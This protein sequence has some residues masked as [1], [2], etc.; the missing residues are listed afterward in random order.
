MRRPSKIVEREER[1]GPRSSR[2]SRPEGE[3]L[4]RRGNKKDWGP[5]HSLKEA[6]TR[7]VFFVFVTRHPELPPA[8]DRF[9]HASTRTKAIQ[10]LTS[11]GSRSRRISH[12]QFGANLI[13]AP[14]RIRGSRK[15]VQCV[16]SHLAEHFAMDI[17]GGD[18]RIAIFRE[19]GLVKACN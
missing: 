2:E 1:D 9:L 3:T 5:S 18:G 7:K 19:T 10:T 4:Q 15:L 6:S 11:Q 8:T 17:D 14:L 12:D 16:S 13:F